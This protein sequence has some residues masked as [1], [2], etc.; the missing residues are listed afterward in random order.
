[1]EPAGL[2]WLFHLMAFVKLGGQN[3][4]PARAEVYCLSPISSPIRAAGYRRGQNFAKEKKKVDLYYSS[5]GAI[6]YPPLA[7]LDTT[8]VGK[9]PCWLQQQ[10]HYCGQ[11]LLNRIIV[12]N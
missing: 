11:L 4:T 12:D 8:K 9:K 1:M 2:L 5:Q 6:F 7:S 3:G 10:F